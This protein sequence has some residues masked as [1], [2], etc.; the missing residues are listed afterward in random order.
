MNG[1]WLR[2]WEFCLI[3]SAV[4]FAFIT[5][6]IAWNGLGEIRDLIRGRKG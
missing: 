3:V 6:K 1:W 5:V 2:F 4:S